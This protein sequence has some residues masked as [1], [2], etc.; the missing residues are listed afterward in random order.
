MENITCIRQFADTTQINRCKD[1]VTNLNGSFTQVA[2]GL[3]MAGNT[4]RLKILFLLFD[5][6]RLCVCDLSDILGV[7]VSAVSQHLRKMK[8]R[9]LIYSVKEGQTIYYAL[10]PEYAIILKP[11]FKIIAD[12]E[13][14][15]VL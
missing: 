6:S 13:I 14:L 5:E 7:T 1:K 11:F 4:I 15:E 10:M 8:D 2:N 9:N 12:T 3:E